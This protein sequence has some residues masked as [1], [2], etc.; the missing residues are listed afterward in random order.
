MTEG[1]PFTVSDRVVGWFGAAG[2][3]GLFE[4]RERYMRYPHRRGDPAGRGDR[5][6]LSAS[7]RGSP[8]SWTVDEQR[9]LGALSGDL[10]DQEHV[11]GVV[12]AGMDAA[13][14]PAR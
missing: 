13:R 2:F 9:A 11:A 4:V 3:L 1:E 12:L 6:L 5:R 7:L 8:F 10:E 14:R